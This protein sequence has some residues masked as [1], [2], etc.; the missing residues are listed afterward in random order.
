M[1]TP[2]EPLPPN[3]SGDYAPTKDHSKVLILCAVV[4]VMGGFL[5]MQYLQKL[6]LDALKM[7]GRPPIIT[8]LKE[9]LKATEMSGREVDLGQLEGKVWVVGFLYTVC[10]RGCAG[11]AV[12]M[13]KLQDEF[14]SDPNFHL[15]SVSLY[16]EW[17]TPERLRAWTESQGFKGENWWFLTGDG[18]KLRGYMKDQF[19]LPVFEIPKEKQ[20]NEFDRFEHK[21]ALI[22]IDSKLRIRGAYDFS[23]FEMNDVFG[24]KIRKDLKEVLGEVGKPE[25]E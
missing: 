7:E 18:D 11:L 4:I 20:K 23:S 5:F 25:K 19:K 8:K 2:P 17:D 1:S 14:G 13:K 21:L 22:L 9:N 10:P 6:K 3:L 24:E 16:P 15:V 12:E